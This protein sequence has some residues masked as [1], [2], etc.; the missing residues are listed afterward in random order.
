MLQL[1]FKPVDSYDIIIKW[2][3]KFINCCILNT[4]YYLRYPKR[5]FREDFRKHK[6]ILHLLTKIPKFNSDISILNGK[7][8]KDDYTKYMARFLELQECADIR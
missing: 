2:V 4:I 1:G 7:I 6:T 5:G 8:K 3:K